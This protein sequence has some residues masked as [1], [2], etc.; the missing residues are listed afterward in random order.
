[1]KDIV[2]FEDGKGGRGT[3]AQLIKRGNKR[4]LIKF[5]MYDYELEIN[6]VVTEW[7]KLW[8]PPWSRKTNKWRKHNNKRKSA[9]YIHEDSN[10][11]YSDREQTLEFEVQFRKYRDEDYC[12]KLFGEKL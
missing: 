4:V 9:M 11:F 8:K 7:F 3:K 10:E 12:N 6:R 1:M 2:I 5:E